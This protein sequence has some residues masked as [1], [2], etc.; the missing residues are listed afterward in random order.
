MA[1]PKRKMTG[2]VTPKGT[3]PGQAS[4][5]STVTTQAGAV[6]ASTRY[7]PPSRADLDESPRWLPILM[8]VLITLGLMCIILRY[9]V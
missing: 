7:T 4:T 5:P 8:A 9:L 6:G 1:P 3:R 2:R